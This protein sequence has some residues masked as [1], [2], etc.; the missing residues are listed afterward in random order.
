MNPSRCVFNGLDG[1]T[2]EPLLAP[3]T[4]EELLEHLDLDGWSP[5]PASRRLGFGVDPRDLA[6]SG[7]GVAFAPGLA[8]EE[9]REIRD[10]LEPLLA[11]R[12][13]QA[14]DR[15]RDFG[16]EL[17]DDP[18][19]DG[20]L[21]LLGRLGAGAGPVNP[22]E[23]PYYLLLVGP[24]GQV[25]FRA[26]YELGLAFAVGRLDF[27]TA[28]EYARYA[29]SV[30]AAESGRVRRARKVA[31]VA[32]AHDE[33][34]RMSCHGLTGPLAGRLLDAAATARDGWEVESRL[35]AEAHKDR[36]ASVLGGDGAPALAFTAS[37]GVAFPCGH[38]RQ[39]AEQGALVCQERGAADRA[40]LG[41]ERLFGASDVSDTADV[42]G[43]VSF[44]FA[45][46]GA[47]SPAR[48][49]FA[50]RRPGNPP[51]PVAPEARVAALPRRLLGHPKGGAL[52]TV[53]HV[54]RAW[55]WSFISGGAYH[56]EVFESTVLELLAGF[57]V[58]AAMQHF[59]ERHGQ[60]AGILASTLDRRRHG[61]EVSADELARLWT[62]AVDARNY[63]ILGDPAVRLAAEA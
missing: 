35:E 54:D 50:H 18:E 16:E 5:A 25:S 22:D 42:A 46:Y 52:A 37:H 47:G 61:G 51:A 13:R 39:E 9:R 38:E 49:S 33:A 14:G 36:F 20:G 21:S 57:P 28:E 19:R 62:A 4:P 2:G 34:T 11:L 60:L 12:K 15:F 23:A 29:E 6:A 17:F 3:M 44:H 27:A 40:G 1:T 45:C 8:P 26:Q 59:G 41:P 43:L 10:A 32:P 48:D 63:V 31:L 30:V 56:R 24:P 7:W 53:G 58:G 55:A